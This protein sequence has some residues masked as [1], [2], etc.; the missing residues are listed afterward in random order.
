[1]PLHLLY[2]PVKIK[3]LFFIDYLFAVNDNIEIRK[4]AS[5]NKNFFLMIVIALF[6]VSCTSSDNNE[7]NTKLLSEGVDTPI[8]VT[9]Y[10]DF[11]QS[12]DFHFLKPGDKVAVISPSALPSQEKVDATINGLKE[13]GYEPVE[14][15]YVCVEVRTLQNCIEDLKWALEDPDIKAIYC[16][17]GGSAAWEVLDNISLSLIENANKPIIGY[18]DIT[19]YLSAW[20][21]SDEPSIH[22]C[23]ADTFIDLDKKCVE[24]EK[25]I[26][27]GEVPVYQVEGSEYDR[28]GS[29]TGILIGGN[30]STLTATLDTPYDVTAIDEPYI[31]FLE[32][33]EEDMEHIHRFLSILE[34]Q[35]VLDKA[36]G[37]IFGEWVDYPEECETYNG[38]SRGGKFKSVAD[39]ISRQFLNDRNIPVAFGFPAG[40][41]EVN[42]PLMMG[43][44]LKLDVNEDSYTLEWLSN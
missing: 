12:E 43:T 20:T 11:S 33:V 23:M 34:H 1:M 28:K 4:G 32:D 29:A 38:N 18:S 30:L 31:L 14:G 13:W 5:M 16:V 3:Y 19:N 37:L 10:K 44:K 22:S 35:G 8:T 25:K 41:G 6:L 9:A 21:V 40:H 42:Y 36:V 26:L 39:M 15:K 7:G 27:N 17:R 2:I 24:V